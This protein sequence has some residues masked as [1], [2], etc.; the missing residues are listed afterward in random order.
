MNTKKAKKIIT[1]I[2][3]IL[4]IISLFTGIFVL[5]LPKECIIILAEKNSYLPFVGSDVKELNQAKEEMNQAQD[6]L[7]QAQD[8]IQKVL[9]LVR[10]VLPDGENYIPSDIKHQ[11]RASYV[12]SKIAL[13]ASEMCV[14]IVKKQVVH[15]MEISFVF[16]F[17]IF[18]VLF[19]L[20]LLSSYVN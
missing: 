12:W 16:I 10:D 13:D 8:E 19:S 4:S 11:L 7:H 1:I 14:D 9:W 20:L 3:G 18:F 6:E 15:S 17:G 2:L 5:S